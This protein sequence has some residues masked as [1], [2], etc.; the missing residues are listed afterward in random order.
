MVN[1]FAVP[2]SIQKVDSRVAAILWSVVSRIPGRSE[3]PINVKTQPYTRNLYKLALAFLF[4]I[5]LL[6]A[7]PP[8]GPDRPIAPVL[9][10]LKPFI[11]HAMRRTGVPGVA[12]A[13][14][15]RDKVVYLEGFGFRKAG[16]RARVDSD[17]VF[18]L[19]SVSKPIASTIVAALVGNHEVDWDDRIVD[20]DPGFELSDQSV[21]QQL[22]IRDLLSHRS[23]LPT[24][25]GDVLEDLGLS[26]PEILHQMRLLP[27]PG[28]FRKSYQYS[29][30]GYTEGAIAAS[31]AVHVRWEDLAR[32][33]LFK[34]LGMTS[35]SYRYSDYKDTANKAAIQTIIDGTAVARY[36]RDPDAEAPAGSASSSVRDLAEWLRLQLAAGSWNGQSIVSADALRETR[37]PQIQRGT[38]QNGKP[39]Y[40]GL[41]WN[42]E[43][44]PANNLIIGHSGAFVLGA[45]TTVRFSPSQQLGIVVLTNALPTGLAEA[46]ANT[47]FDLYNYGAPTQD[48]LTIFSGFFKGYVDESNNSSTDYSKLTPPSSPAPGKPLSA[49]AGTYRNEYYGRIEISEQSG[50][51]WMRLPDTGAVYTLSHWDGDTFTYRFE[52]EQGIGSRGVVFTVSGTPSV[53]IENLALEGNGVFTRN[54]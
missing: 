37:S 33:R 16:H 11:E 9:R 1:S 29:N 18:Q 23:G 53:L 20:L 12:V 3:T 42:I 40:Y 27:L 26:R 54:D 21:T 31:K 15:Y 51:L 39:L 52:A 5:S 25:A 45:G 17:T 6:F 30:F 36:H 24:S 8:E 2:A 35:T 46:T 47:F 41:G 44:D 34:P 7:G 48:W 28:Q 22:T 19:A 50:S 43:H 32:E 49:Y 4:G 13:V 14:V 38:D 10:E